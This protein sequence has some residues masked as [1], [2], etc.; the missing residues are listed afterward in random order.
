MKHF[1]LFAT[2]F[3]TFIFNIVIAQAPAIEWQKSMGGSK[4]ETTSSVCPTRDGG[5]IMVGATASA[6]GDVTQNAGNQDAWVVLSKQ[7]WYQRCLE[8]RWTFVLYR[9]HG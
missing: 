8:H 7:R 9:L 1:Y 2:F 3:F 5:Y 4:T 6:N